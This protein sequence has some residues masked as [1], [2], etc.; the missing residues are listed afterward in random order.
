M[1]FLNILG[2]VG[3]GLRQGATFMQQKNVQDQQLQMQQER[4]DWLRQDNAQKTADRD[5]TN[6]M[7]QQYRDV[8]A[9]EDLDDMGKAFEYAKVIAP[10]AKREH[11]EVANKTANGLYQTFGRSAIEA[12]TRGDLS[13]LQRAADVKAP[14]TKIATDAKG[15]NIIVET[16][17][18]TLQQID[19]RGL[20]TNLALSDVYRTMQ[21]EAT[22][23][24][25]AKS[26]LESKIRKLDSEVTLNEAKALNQMAQA[27]GQAQFI[28][29]ENGNLMPNPN[30]RATGK[31]GK[32]Q[33]PD[34]GLM[35]IEDFGKAAKPFVAD[36]A[37]F[38]MARAYNLYTNILE[39]TRTAGGQPMSAGQR[40]AA[41]NDAIR[42]ARG[43]GIQT[44]DLRNGR[45]ALTANIDGRRYV[46]DPDY[47]EAQALT[48]KDEKGNPR[49]TAQDMNDLYLN[50]MRSG[51]VSNPQQFGVV[52]QMVNDPEMLA[53]AQ[54]RFAQGDVRM[55]D[56][57]RAAEVVKRGIARANETAKINDR[58]AFSRLF[59]DPEPTP[60]KPAESKRSSPFADRMLP[61]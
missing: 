12:M 60:E 45:L 47:T 20:L 5:L 57:L 37:E 50:A 52:W 31:A 53:E 19:R 3:A 34:N 27:N 25:A 14:G 21:D 2:G 48:L 36:G 18:G 8:Y 43:E 16:P 55:G 59:N 28:E 22:S 23:K 4:Q 56:M 61:G 30:Y 29:D 7:D 46:L 38:D 39:N 33:Q 40:A 10:R 32:V 1:S 51:A 6:W 26:E 41:F 13:L 17:D 42:L 24:K 58:S 49:Y 11:L 15:D 54:Q 35:S 44:P 9:R